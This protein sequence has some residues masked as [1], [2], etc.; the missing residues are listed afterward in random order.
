MMS[1]KGFTLIELLVVISIIGLLS[2]VVLASLNSAREKGRLAAARQSDS[3]MF[4]AEADQAVGIW[5]F[6]ECS[7]IAAD[8][9]GHGGTGT[10]TGTASWSTDTATGKG[11]SVS[12]DGSGYV[13]VL[14]NPDIEIGANDLT[15]AAWIK[16]SNTTA[17]STIISHGAYDLR[18]TAAGLLKVV[19]NSTITGTAS[20]LPST[21]DGKWHFVSGIVSRTAGGYICIDG[22]CGSVNPVNTAGDLTNGAALTIGTGSSGSFTGQIDGVRIYTKTLTASEVGKIYA[23]GIPDHQVAI[24]SLPL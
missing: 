3:N 4:E 13:N 2:S 5:D 18:M 11:C 23:E 8:R 6:D 16:T 15:L 22:A 14:D 10:L 7:G 24:S 1:R 9:S 12:F 17:A 20:G 19:V 21:N